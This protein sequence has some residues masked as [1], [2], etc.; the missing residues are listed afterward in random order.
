M[1][2]LNLMSKN[3]D[4]G[5]IQRCMAKLTPTEPLVVGFSGGGDS[6]ALLTDLIELGAKANRQVHALI[7]NHKIKP[8]ADAEAA[9]ALTQAL[10]LGANAQV[11]NWDNEPLAG[12]ANA[13][14][15]RY[16]LL[17]AACKSLG[18]SHL[19]LAHTVDDQVETFFLRLSAGSRVRGLAAMGFDAPYPI[20]PQG[21][22]LR[23]LRPL[24]KSNRKSLRTELQHKKLIWL[25]DSANRDEKY[26]RVRM[27]KQLRSLY[28]VGLE[29]KTTKN[30]IATFQ[31]IAD[32]RQAAVQKQMRIAITFSPFGFAE[33]QVSAASSFCS[34]ILAKVLEKTMLAVSGNLRNKHTEESLVQ[35]W[36]VLLQNQRAVTVNGCLLT[37][38]DDLVRI[39]RD[40]GAV[41]GRGNS[42]S[43][44]SVT[45]AKNETI[46]FD[47]RWQITT[48]QAGKV[49]PLGTNYSTL[50]PKQR[51]FLDKIPFYAKATTP[52]LLI[53]SGEFI[54]LHKD[55]PN[56][57]SFIGAVRGMETGTCFA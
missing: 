37:Y 34:S 6:L 40:P 10:A 42:I 48:Q 24:L 20:W 9:T 51:S 56:H 8:S 39:F 44:L 28:N 26:A 7:V 32:I 19:W 55:C 17:A 27:R 43:S 23:V 13:R 54:L 53:N 12:H 14:T 5:L 49:V 52:V 33:V 16:Q 3:T 38:K 22:G 47:Q 25:E 2:P 30:I 41:T 57:I 4:T 31:Q 11:L 1:R 29:N 18:A 50:C 35:V 15:A 45:V 21:A 46:I 36:D